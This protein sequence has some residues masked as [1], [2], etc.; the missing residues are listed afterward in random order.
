VFGG[1][2]Q[3]VGIKT[4]RFDWK[5]KHPSQIRI[6]E[7]DKKAYILDAAAN[8]PWGWHKPKDL[9]GHRRIRPMEN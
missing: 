5:P 3:G 2:G 8:Q 4:M 7:C 9:I 6:T 1:T